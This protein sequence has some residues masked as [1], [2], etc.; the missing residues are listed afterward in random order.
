MSVASRLISFLKSKQT[1]KGATHTGMCRPLTGA[2]RIEGEEEK[3]FWDLYTELYTTF[4][5]NGQFMQLGITEVHQEYGPVLVDLDMKTPMSWGVKRKYTMM[6]IQTIANKYMDVI[7]QYVDVEPVAHIFEK[8]NPRLQSKPGKEDIIKDG[9]HIMFMNVVVNKRIHKEIHECVMDW[10][11]CNTH[12]FDHIVEHPGKELVDTAIV[13]GNWLIR[14]CSKD[15][16]T[17]PYRCTWRM[18]ANACEPTRDTVF[19]PR[20]FPIRGFT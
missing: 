20:L 14:G 2:W 12:R 4:E 19:E 18:D 16:D 10:L 7:K 9:V 8:K 5:K 15:T 11:E 6:D 17:S 1:D 13:C 3:T